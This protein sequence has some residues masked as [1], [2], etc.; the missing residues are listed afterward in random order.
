MKICV[1]SGVGTGT[2]KL[3]AFDNAL[4]SC[5]VNNFNLIILSSVIPPGS[6]IIQTKRY[7]ALSSDFGKRLY[8]VRA[9][10]RSEKVNDFICS[11]L[12][13][14]Q[15]EDNRGFFVEY[16]AEGKDR[17]KVDDEVKSGI[18]N[19]LKDLVQTRGMKFEAKRI[20]SM[21]S[22]TQVGRKPACALVIAVY[23]TEPWT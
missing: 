9:E 15:L 5:G 13:W 3:A 2:T 18:N 8:V 7:S 20:N 10:L 14:Y 17:K 1:V 23:Q 21:L 16:E 11:G 12:G 19:S 6:K 22:T 4:F